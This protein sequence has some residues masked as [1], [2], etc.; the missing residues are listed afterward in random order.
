MTSSLS[1]GLSLGWASSALGKRS[2]GSFSDDSDVFGPG[3]GEDASSDG[4]F[5]RHAK[6]HHALDME[7]SPERTE[8]WTCHTVS[9]S[10]DVD[11]GSP[12]QAMR[13]ENPSHMRSPAPADDAARR[14][15][16]PLL[17]DGSASLEAQRARGDDYSTDPLSAL[18]SRPSGSRADTPLIKA[19]ARHA[20]TSPSPL[21]AYRPTYVGLKPRQR[22]MLSHTALEMMEEDVGGAAMVDSNDSSPLPGSTTPMSASSSS[23][24]WPS[25]ESSPS[26]MRHGGAAAA[27]AAVGRMKTGP[28]VHDDG[29]DLTSPFRTP[30]KAKAAKTPPS[31][32]RRHQH[33][34]GLDRPGT[35]PGGK[36]MLRYTMG[37]REDCELCRR[38]S[39]S[40]RSVR[41][42]M[43]FGGAKTEIDSGF[44]HRPF[45]SLLVLFISF[46]F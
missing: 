16:A 40:R 44:G 4:L 1:Q 29:M 19:F 39:E 42:P 32:F 5:A 28:A 14:T 38:K 15:V 26:T 2:R 45:D 25:R 7:Q 33:S 13:I 22:S 18:L 41:G 9:Q 12:L 24:P 27:A 3:A 43:F 30:T 37:F 17:E 36:Q 46:Y 35:P 10:S 31:G 11:M 21:S 8:V 20:P 23:S 34:P 6:R